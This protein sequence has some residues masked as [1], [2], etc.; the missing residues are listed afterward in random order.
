MERSGDAD[1]GSNTEILP[2]GYRHLTD[3]ERCR[4][5]ILKQSGESNARKQLG[6]DRATIGLTR[7]AGRRGY[8]QAQRLATE[9]RSVARP[10]R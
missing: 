4:L 1:N 5:Y 2:K 8:R 10:G 9:R 3:R 6:R 7:N